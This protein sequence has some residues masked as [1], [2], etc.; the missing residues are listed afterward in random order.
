MPIWFPYGLSQ[1]IRMQAHERST[2]P[3]RPNHAPR[4]SNSD[5]AHSPLV[6]SADGWD[7]TS[8]PARPELQSSRRPTAGRRLRPGLQDTLDRLSR[9]AEPPVNRPAEPADG[10]PLTAARPD[11]GPDG[12]LNGRGPDVVARNGASPDGASRNGA[13]PDSAPQ[14]S[15]LPEDAP[16]LSSAPQVQ[17]PAVA[18]PPKPRAADSVPGQQAA[19]ANVAPAEPAGDRK[20]RTLRVGVVGVGY[21]GIKH[22]RALEKVDGVAA[23]VGIDERLAGEPDSTLTA[24]GVD[25][26]GDVESALPNVDAL[27]IA[28]PPSTHTAIG[29]RA[30]E[31]GKHVLI[32]KP[33]ATSSAEARS[34]IEAADAAGVILMAGHTF[35]HNAAVHKLRDLVRGRD[36]GQLYY[37]DC[38]RLNLGLYRE[39]V[40]VIADLAPHDISIANYVLGSRPTT[41]TAWGSRFV[42]TD[43][44]D[45]AFLRLD[46][47]DV[48]VRASIQVSWLSPVKV[49]RVTAV[50]SQRMAV[51]DDLAEDERIRVYDK[52]A[53]PAARDNG[54]TY[55]QGDTV[56]PHVEFAEPLAVQ[57]QEFVRCVQTGDRPAADG[58]SGLAVV[59]ALD[60]AQISLREQRPVSIAELNQV[61]SAAAALRLASE[62]PLRSA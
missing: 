6:S 26:Y 51:Y 34:L 46:Y 45:V 42:G 12:G 3:A 15:A 2:G 48:G 18:A 25:Q 61:P 58:T 32:E 4:A 33:L 30:I 37:L 14:R 16:D 19:P 9:P 22:V 43:H 38:A 50:G 35:E 36:L 40:G 1:V 23:V 57:D 17:A 60:A 21:W 54:M 62:P 27:V 41:V 10:A 13:S 11:A 8:R 31:A 55:H 28:T 59:Q 7:G 56:L 29:L 5:H 44:E 24:L 20:T 39:D 47:A 49:R 53:V 52:S